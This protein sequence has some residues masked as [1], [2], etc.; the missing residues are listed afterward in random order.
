[1]AE[2]LLQNNPAQ[3]VPSNFYQDPI[4]DMGFL[5]KLGVALGGGGGLDRVRARAYDL[6]DRERLL[7]RQNDLSKLASQIEGGLPRETAL[8]RYAG[9]TGDFSPILRSGQEGGATGSLVDR[10]MAENPNLSFSDALGQVQTGFRRGVQ[11]EGGRATPIEG[12]GGALG[13]LGRQQRFGQERGSLLAQQQLRPQIEAATTAARSGAQFR[14]AGAQNLP[15]LKRTLDSREL[16]EDFLDEKINSVLD[17]SNEWTTGFRGA[18]TASIPGTPAFDLRSD[19]NT[20]LANAG[21]DQL[22]QMRDNSPT[23]GALGQV[24]ERELELLQ[25]AAQNL[26]T[27]QSPVQFRRNLRDFQ[28]QRRKSLEAIRKAYREDVNR[29]SPSREMA[30][31]AAPLNGQQDVNFGGLK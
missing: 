31:E 28:K 19:V 10:L 24:S 2:L 18:V 14:S 13:E 27:S 29:F 26:E 17:R 1:M 9:I 21:F 16:K 6:Q 7:Q 5:Q 4:A 15:T 30:Q 25:S 23:G 20:I 3:A 11:L 8:Q 22:Q 12:L